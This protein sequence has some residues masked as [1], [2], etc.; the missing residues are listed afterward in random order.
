MCFLLLLFFLG[1]GG[2]GIRGGGVG[3]Q[4]WRKQICIGQA[5][6]NVGRRFCT[7]P[8]NC[9]SLLIFLFNQYFIVDK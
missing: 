6:Q 5:K 8:E 9:L 1:G 2:A 3:I 4:G 7:K